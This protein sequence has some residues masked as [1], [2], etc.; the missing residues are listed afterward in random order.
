MMNR[1]SGAALTVSYTTRNT[2]FGR[3]PFPAPRLGRQEKSPC[4]TPSRRQE[5]LSALG[6]LGTW[7]SLALRLA[8]LLFTGVDC[9][10][11]LPA[12]QK[13]V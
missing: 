11:I 3:F 9:G 1:I 4:D 6:V 10:P 8:G 12:I 5:V 13:R 7:G 2:R